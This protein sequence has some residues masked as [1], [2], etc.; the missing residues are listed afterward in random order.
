MRIAAARQSI[1]HDFLIYKYH[2]HVWPRQ[3]HV[4][5][6]CGQWCYATVVDCSHAL[7]PFHMYPFE[8]RALLTLHDND[9]VQSACTIYE[10]MCTLPLMLVDGVPVDRRYLSRAG[11]QEHLPAFQQMASEVTVD[12]VAVQERI[13]ADKAKERQRQR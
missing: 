4:A 5:T 7:Q 1:G 6:A 11:Q 8:Y 10:I 2:C 3:L 12:E 13:K 9:R